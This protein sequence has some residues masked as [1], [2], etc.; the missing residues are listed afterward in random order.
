MPSWRLSSVCRPPVVDNEKLIGQ[1]SENPRLASLRQQLASELAF[2]A[3][4][5][6]QFDPMLILMA[7]S[8]I[9]QVVIA[10]RRKNSAEQIIADFRNART[11][12]RWRMLTIQRK[13]NAL[14]L[15]YCDGSDCNKELLYDALLD[16]AENSADEEIEEILNLAEAQK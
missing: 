3:G 14:W 16:I 13:L 15:D 1:I 6:V 8:I 9:V 2:R 11:L 12:P 5:D 10:C 4:G 7:I